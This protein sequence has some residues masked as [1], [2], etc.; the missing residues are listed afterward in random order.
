MDEMKIQENLVFDTTSGELVGFIDLGHPL[1]T[2]ANTDEETPIA[3]HA[4][5]FLVR[6]LCTSLK[7][8]VAYYFTGNV[9][10]FQLLPLFWRV[11]GVL[12]TT[13]KLWV[14]AAV[15]DGASP[16]RKFFALHAKL[17]CTLSCGLVYKNPNI[18]FLAWMIYFFADVPHLIKTARNCFYNSEYG[19]YSWFVKFNVCCLFV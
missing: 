17:G 9:T 6:G 15:N 8:V 5:A 10:S 18:F 13:V 14:I 2:F 11:V 16:N 1:T 12:E 4:L 3:S 19:S 7:H